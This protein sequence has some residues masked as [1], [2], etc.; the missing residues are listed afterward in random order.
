LSAE[1][2]VVAY[3]GVHQAYQHA[4]AAYEIGEL[5]RFYCALYQDPSKAGARHARYVGAG[6]M[7]GRRAE[8]LD[9]GRVVEVPWPLLA[10]VAGDRL[11]PRGAGD[12]LAAN[13]AFDFWVSRRLAA[14]PP[15]LFIGTASSDLHSLKVL[16]RRGSYLMHDCPGLHPTLEH[17]LLTEAAELAGVRATP[18]LPRFGRPM[19]E[20]RK[21]AE[22]ALADTLILR[23]DFQR[24]SFEAAGFAAER[25]FVSSSWVDAGFWR[26]LQPKARDA[27]GA[28]LKLLFVGSMI[29]RKGLPFLL[30]AVEV[31]GSAVQLTAVGPRSAQTDQLLGAGLAN[32]TWLAPQP[33]ES[34]RELY[35]S[36]DVFILPSI[37]DTFG[38]VAL[39]A[40]ASGMPVIVTDNCGAPVPDAAWRVPAMD[41]ASLAARMMEYAD[42]RS[43]VARRG[44]EAERFAAGFSQQAYRRVI[45]ERIAAILK[46]RR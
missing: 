16:K 46:E 26:R 42:D 21:L 15:K 32:V 36:H 27:P 43:L 45:G 24:R 19:M 40:M 44:E 14:D 37:V 31:C 10:K 9:L 34:L 12:W 11:Y 30:R 29:L 23:S 7:D 38:F 41:P 28:P 13:K 1:R 22:Y 39:E 25:L 6:L 18:R 3:A 17:Q 8:G 4:L 2:V 20:G 33:R 35:Q 5:A